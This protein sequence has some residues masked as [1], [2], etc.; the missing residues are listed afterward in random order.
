[1]FVV[2]VCGVY[3]MSFSFVF[4]VVYPAFCSM[5]HSKPPFPV[6]G[7]CQ[8]CVGGM[9]RCLA[10]GLCTVGLSHVAVH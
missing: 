6:V 2:I 3:A 9:A 7:Y 4:L 8:L 1:M 10:T 5:C